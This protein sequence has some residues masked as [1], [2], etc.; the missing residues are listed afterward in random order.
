MKFAKN[1]LI[2]IL[3]TIIM[4]SMTK[5]I[6]PTQ[7]YSKILINPYYTE[8]FTKNLIYNYILSINPPD[9][10]TNVTLAIINFN[11]YVTSSPQTFIMKV[12]N[13]SCNNPSYVASLSG[14]AT[15]SFD[16][17]NIINKI[18]D[19]NLTLTSIKD[20]GGLTGWL[21]LTY[22]NKPTGKMSMFG[23]EY[24]VGDKATIFLQLN[25]EQNL[26]INNGYCKV[27]IYYPSSYNTSHPIW[28]KEAP[29]IF[30]EGSNG[31]YY[32]D[33]ISPSYEGIYMLSATCSYRY[34]GGFVYS[35]SGAEVNKPSRTT[36][37]GTYVGDTIFLNDY[38]DWIY[39]QCSSSSGGTKSCQ[40]TYDY[41][42]SIHFANLTNITDIS[43]YYMG[44][45]SVKAILSFEAYNWTSNS[46][47]RLSNNLTFSGTSPNVPIGIGEF[48]S[49][50]IPASGTLNDDKIIR[51][52][53]TSTFGSTYYEFDNWLNI[54]ILTASGNIIELKGSGELHITNFAG[55]ITINIT[56]Q[57]T[58]L[59]QNITNQLITLQNNIIADNNLTREQINALNQTINNLQIGINNNFTNIQN[60][61]TNIITQNNL[62]QEMIINTNQTINNNIQT[63]Q[64]MITSLNTTILEQFNITNTNTINQ[65]TLLQANLTSQLEAMNQNMNQKCDNII[66][67]LQNLTIM[68]NQI[69]L[70][71]IE[72]RNL[73]QQIWDY[74][75][76]WLNITINQINNKIDILINMTNTTTQPTPLSITATAEEFLNCITGS[77]WIIHAYV[78]GHYNEPLN[79]LT[80]QCNIT[81][82][83]WGFSNM[84]YTPEGY[85]EYKNTCPDPADWNWS[86]S[87]DE[88]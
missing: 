58:A 72:T 81:T 37:Y 87:C 35:M 38:E 7:S 62:T 24:Q 2:I 64:A 49:N 86:I 44:E 68:I 74:I 52:R 77:D 9:G 65:I 33:L 53:L 26:P 54:N 39:T 32:Y 70:T 73:A 34:Y 80:A 83:I 5:A 60:A 30:K 40:A 61:L 25:D 4:A 10:I 66:N 29:L 88:I 78:Y 47:I 46:W 3:L 14:F 18:G 51:V 42:T 43:L 82:D 36:S 22:M 21:D 76:G 55:S 16:C 23:T 41:N 13:A 28:I 45:A 48:V 17:T 12:N 63:T 20:S 84:T 50:S 19:Y 56:N 75:I 8:T 79:N 6:E 27:D 31:L 69:N 15:I 57:L 85:F 71:T 1:L 11:L 67:Y 59:Q